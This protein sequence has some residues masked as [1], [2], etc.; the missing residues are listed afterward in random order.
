MYGSQATGLAKKD[1]DI[2]LAVLF[3][4]K[5]DV[6][7]FILQGQFDFEIERLLSTEVDVQNLNACDVGFVYQV[8][9]EGQLIYQKHS[10][11]TANFQVKTVQSYFDLKP[12]FD[13]YYLCLSER[14][15]RGLIGKTG[16]QNGYFE[17]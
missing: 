13:Q 14:A 17:N 2:D 11:D 4:E 7:T 15:R 3:D 10:F 1:S 6:N 5:K 16:V 8:L 12:T 9:F